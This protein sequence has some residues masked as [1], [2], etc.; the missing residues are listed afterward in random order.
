M[1]TT[2]M[3]LSVTLV[4]AVALVIIH[5]IRLMSA[6]IRHKTLRRVIETHPES[7]ERLIEQQMAEPAT[8]SGDDRLGM[9]L[10][11]I[12]IAMIG[13]SMTA[14]ATGGWTD[15]GIGGALFPLL[16]GAALWLRHIF[17]ERARRR[18]Q[19]H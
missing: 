4:A 13:A 5:L 16:V 9:I 11:A 15:Y 2:E 19:G 18:E 14:G 7:A 6:N 17:V 8:Q 12:G 10:V 3:I 1:P